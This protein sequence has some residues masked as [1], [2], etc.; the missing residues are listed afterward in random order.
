MNSTQLTLYFTVI[1][2]LYIQTQVHC[3]KPQVLTVAYSNTSVLGIIPY[4]STI[5]DPLSYDQLDRHSYIKVSWIYI[6]KPKT[7]QERAYMYGIL[8]IYHTDSIVDSA[9]IADNL[10]QNETLDCIEVVGNLYEE[11]CRAWHVD[12]ARPLGYYTQEC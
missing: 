8:S 3:N 7:V 9:T 5:P 11:W 1:R 2:S 12:L 10:I 6:Y 4:N